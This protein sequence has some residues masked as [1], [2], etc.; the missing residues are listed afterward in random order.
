ML[1]IV[2]ATQH[3]VKPVLRALLSL[4]PLQPAVH[5]V[6]LL[7]QRPARGGHARELPQ[8]SAF[9][10][11]CVHAGPGQELLVPFPGLPHQRVHRRIQVGHGGGASAALPVL[12]PVQHLRHLVQGGAHGR[13]E[14]IQILPRLLQ[15]LQLHRLPATGRCSRRGRRAH[16]AGAT[17]GLLLQHVQFVQGRVHPPV[18]HCQHMVHF[19]RHCIAWVQEFAQH[20]LSRSDLII[21]VLPDG[22]HLVADLALAREA[23]VCAV[24]VVHFLC[25]VLVVIRRLFQLRLDIVK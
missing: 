1:L 10:S 24:E 19:A 2:H 6:D 17:N 12:E 16:N 11:G 7:H 21:P 23:K 18:Q 22:V 9:V 8:Q 4:R 20:A 15:L 14:R 3:L 13:L 5:L 25:C